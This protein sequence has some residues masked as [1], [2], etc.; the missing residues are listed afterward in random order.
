MV[1]GYYGL[2]VMGVIRV[3]SK[4]KEVKGPKNKKYTITDHWFNVS[5]KEEDGSW[6]NRS[7]KMIFS[8]YS[9]K[10]GNNEIILVK[11]AGF[12]ITGSGK[13]RRIALFV[14]DWEYPDE[15]EK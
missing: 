2:H 10:P 4:T 7:M 8:R 12:L 11:D 9:E 5:E 15:E 13:Y 1:K 14:R 3:F 6:F